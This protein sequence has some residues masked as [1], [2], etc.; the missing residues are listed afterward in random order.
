LEGGV[1]LTEKDLSQYKALNARIERNERKLEELHTRDI[2]AVAGKVKGSSREHPY[3]ETYFPVQMSEPSEAEKCRAQIRK[4]E[5]DISS[6]RDKIN[7][8]EKFINAIDDPELQTIFE[9][10]VYEK[11]G[12]VDIAAELDEDKNRTT[13]SRK[14][15]KYIEN[16]HNAPIAQ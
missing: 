4:I 3:I 15:K 13:Y 7:S 9:M 8:I 6:D 11:M 12:W 14:F 16:A 5:R 2:P 1:L 10:R